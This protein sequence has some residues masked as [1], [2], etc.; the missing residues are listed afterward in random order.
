[1]VRALDS[2]TTSLEGVHRTARPQEA[3]RAQAE[4]ALYDRE[5]PDQTNS[6][7]IYDRDNDRG[8]NNDRGGYVGDRDG[9]RDR[10][11]SKG[12]GGGCHKYYWGRGGGTRQGR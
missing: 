12:N 5:H 10:D 3:N 4:R 1:M 9:D 2:A 7:I 6:R 8:Y 11:R